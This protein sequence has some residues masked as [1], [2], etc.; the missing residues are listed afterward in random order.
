M[1]DVFITELDSRAMTIKE[2]DVRLLE[3]NSKELF[4][5]INSNNDSYIEK[6]NAVYLKALKTVDSIL[7]VLST[8]TLNFNENDTSY[9]LPY[10]SKRIFYSPS[11]KY[12]AKRLERYIKSKSYD[13][14]V[15]TDDYEK[16]SEIE[17]NA[18][19]QIFSKTIIANFQ[20]NIQEEIKTTYRY[21]ESI[22]LNSIT[23]RYDPHSNYF[24]EEQNQ[25][26]NTQ[27]SSQVE[28]FGFFLDENEEGII[29]IANIEPGGSAWMSNEVNEGDAFISV[30]IGNE[31]VTNEELN[32]YEIQD[33]LDKTKEDKILLTVK[34]QNGLIKTVKLIKQKTA[35][36]DNSVK[37]Y[38]LSYNGLKVGY[39][40]L[41]S[42]YTDME[43]HNLPGCANDVAK[44]ILKLEND[45]IKGLIIDLRNNGGGSMGEAMNLA[46]IFIDEGPLF[47]IKEKN[48]KPSLVKDINRGSL[49]KK[50]LLVMINETSASASELFSNIVKDYNLGVIVGQT[51]YGKGTAQS[52][53]P[54]DTNLLYTKN[55]DAIKNNI[56]FIKITNS[57]FYRLNGSTHQGNG[58]VPDI[59]LPPTPGY[60]TIKEN[61]ELYFLP[62]DSIVKKVVYI[63]NSKLNT[64]P[65]QSNSAQ[66]IAA[67]KDFK[68]YLQISDSINDVINKTQKVV[69]KFKEYKKFKKDTDVLYNSLE[70]AFEINANNI[71]CLNNTFDLKLEQVNITAREFN[72]K[73]IQSIQKDIFINESFNIMS[74]LINQTR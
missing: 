63:P 74:D 36:V 43:D 67:S 64:Q 71:K 62:P 41:P 21:V 26:F 31:K 15:N 58:V 60:A 35:S 18:K 22:L 45:T 17:F 33:K 70:N 42:F 13:R 48:R 68:R 25:E 37:G 2:S 8:R 19:A 27:L 3:E 50:P 57:K 54:L 5:Q 20:K 65:L 23:L 59:I 72:S 34:K 40:S 6:A 66:R 11:I 24:T 49:Y 29:T 1:V 52:V 30:K 16:L 44:E 39:I 10:G 69:L 38:V 12:H 51:S 7:S 46:G 4:N 61:K 53:L 32:A 56:D 47:I 14:V 28:S 55:K 73:I 9:L